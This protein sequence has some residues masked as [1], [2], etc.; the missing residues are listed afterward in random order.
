MGVVTQNHIPTIG[1]A[2][3]PIAT[4]IIQPTIVI[5]PFGTHH[6][7]HSNFGHHHHH[8]H[9]HHGHHHSMKIF[10]P[11]LEISNWKLIYIYI[12]I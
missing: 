6:H 7:G 10:A 9:H 12:Y 4:P 1:T 8:G 5:D 2:F 11:H 3:G